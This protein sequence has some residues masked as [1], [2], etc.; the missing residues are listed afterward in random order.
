MAWQPRTHGIVRPGGRCAGRTT[1]RQPRS[2]TARSSGTG[3]VRWTTAEPQSNRAGEPH[4]RAVD[5]VDDLLQYREPGRPSQR[6]R[7]DL[8]SGP[9]GGRPLGRRLVVLDEERRLGRPEGRRGEAH[10]RGQRHAAGPDRSPSAAGA[11]RASARRSVAIARASPP[12]VERLR[13]RAARAAEIQAA[14]A[15]A[16]P[17]GGAG[18]IA[19]VGEP[20]TPLA[21]PPTPGRR[22]MNARRAR[23][24]HPRNQASPHSPGVVRVSG[25][26]GEQR[27]I[28]EQHP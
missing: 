23:L 21:A 16:R 4:A 3:A 2:S 28:L 1:Q 26:F 6:V 15:R 19:Q 17:I 22:S 24:P 12:P 20:A 25:Q 27:T 7:Q 11:A 13:R 9:I 5:I 14:S 18:A 10:G 8:A